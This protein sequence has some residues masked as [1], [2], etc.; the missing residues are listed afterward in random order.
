MLILA[1]SQCGLLAFCYFSY[2]KRSPGE[3]F[4]AMPN[5]VDF[6]IQWLDRPSVSPQ[7]LLNWATLAATAT[8]TIDFV[9]YQQNLIDLKDYFT[10][11]GYTAFLKALTEQGA[12]TAI[13]EKKLVLTAVAIGTAVITSE[14][15]VNRIHSWT[16]E[17]PITVTYLSVSTE[18]KE[19]KLVTMTIIQ[20]PTEF[21][22]TGIGIER[23]VVTELGAEIMG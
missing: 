21:A 10:E 6:P 22:S 12:I 16:V 15:E 7:A 20:V 5:G 17:V 9:N 1:L 14:N 13:N 23:Y 3:F 11:N 19:N 2:Y 4:G 8:F 18:E